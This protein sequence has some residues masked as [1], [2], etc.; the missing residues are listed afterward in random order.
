MS[1]GSIVVRSSGFDLRSLSESDS[2]LIPA[3]K[4]EHPDGK[5]KQN[6]LARCGG[7]T[8]GLTRVAT[9]TAPRLKR[10]MRGRMAGG[11]T[12]TRLLATEQRRHTHSCV[13]AGLF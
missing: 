1:P 7:P 5:V 8:I 10:M 6:R 13:G 12:N 9:R 2:S 3:R 4:R 11:M